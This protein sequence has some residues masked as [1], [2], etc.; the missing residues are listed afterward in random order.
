MK[1]SRPVTAL[2]LFALFFAALAARVSTTDPLDSPYFKGTSAM[3][4]RHAVAVA[5]GVSLRAKDGKAAHPDGYVPARYRASGVETATGLVFRAVRFVSDVDERRFVRR[6]TLLFAGLCV[7]TAYAAARR[8]WDCQAG[9]LLAAFL[10]AF[11]PPLVAATNGRAFSHTVFAMFLAGLHAAVALR[12]LSGS[13]AAAMGA[14]LVAAFLLGSWEPAPLYLVL[15]V[16]SAALAQSLERRTR[17]AFVLGHALAIVA[18]AAL[19]PHLAATRALGAWTTATAIA[20]ALAVLI[21]GGARPR[22]RAAAVLVAV[23]VLLTVAMTPFRAGASEQFPALSYLAAR[24]RYV[25]GHPESSAL[26]EWM[27]HLWSLEHAPLPAYQMI[28]VFMPVG[29]CAAALVMNRAARTTRT[30]FVAGI[31]LLVAGAG[32]AALD[33]SALPV[34]ALAMIVAVAGCARAVSAALLSRGLLVAAGAYAALAGVVFA[35][36]AADPA[37]QAAKAAGV[38]DRDPHGFVWISLE[39]TDREL[40]RFISTRTAVQESVLAPDGLSALLLAFSGRTSVQ[41][42]GTTSRAPAQRHVALTRAFYRD[43]ASFYELCREMQIDYVVYSIDV[44]LDGGRYSPR[45]LA[46]EDDIAPDAIAV[47]MHFEPESIRNLTLLYEN[48]H[49]RLFRVTAA[50]EPVFLTDHPPFYQPD[51]FVRAGRNLETFRERVVY[52]MITYADA[53]DARRRGDAELARRRLAFCVEQAP[54]FT[55]VR[56]ALADALMDLG[57]YEEAREQVAAVIGYAPDNSTALYDA[58]FIEAQLGR[59]ERAKPYLALL[60]AQT[61]DRAVIDRARALQTHLEQG[62]PLR[63]GA[64]LDH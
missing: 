15:W 2:I 58:A 49:Y 18:S 48:D 36:T 6:F 17:A 14:A 57:R 16:V 50:P 51:I 28:Q 41:L 27:R 13:R 11:L 54:R 5:D 53:V 8:L 39:N 23:G 21:P 10:V 1:L 64:P 47:K 45:Y 60:L 33:R 44:L 46:G 52:L 35:G 34:A 7:F 38:A 29:L 20:A 63:P 19:F 22:A 12:A 31:L 26:S 42:C 55:K 9:G 3:S 32:A 40:V 37:H 59:P 25:A 24:L 43:E 30:R 56:L 4:Y 61:G 62:L